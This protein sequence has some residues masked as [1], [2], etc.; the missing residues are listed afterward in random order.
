MGRIWTRIKER[1]ENKGTVFHL[2]IRKQY[3]WTHSLNSAKITSSSA[4]ESVECTGEFK[5]GTVGR[6]GFKKA[7]Q[8]H[9]QRCLVGEVWVGFQSLLF[10]RPHRLGTLCKIQPAEIFGKSLTGMPKANLMTTWFLSLFV[11]IF[12]CIFSNLL[13]IQQF[14]EF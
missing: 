4:E 6:W 1:K 2:E 11:L 9:E 7:S 13:F 5:R 3:I 10:L 12:K 8:V 14:K